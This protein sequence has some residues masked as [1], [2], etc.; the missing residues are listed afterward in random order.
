MTHK[1][2]VGYNLKLE[3]FRFF[4]SS[5]TA[6]VKTSSIFAALFFC[7]SL[8]SPEIAQAQQRH[9]T[10][11]LPTQPSPAPP[12][13]FEYINQNTF[14]EDVD[15]GRSTS[16]VRVCPRGS[17][18]VSGSCWQA[19]TAQLFPVSLS[20]GEISCFNSTP[21]S[22]REF[23][24]S[25]VCAPIHQHRY[26]YVGQ[27]TIHAEVRSGSWGPVVRPCGRGQSL[28][29]A[30]C[31]INSDARLVPVSISAQGQDLQCLNTSSRSENHSYSAVCAD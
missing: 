14:R 17:Q 5:K 24:Y 27:S 3:T 22:V 10:R 2:F 19:H 9:H 31:W 8:V 4:G 29:S 13:G 15:S 25:V 16:L 18:I 7:L 21:D 11:G 1:I 23:G 26:T 28:V 12:R 20:G 30:V 6:P